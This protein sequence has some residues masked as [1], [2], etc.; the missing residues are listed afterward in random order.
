ME[1]SEHALN[2]SAYSAYSEAGASH[3]SPHGGSQT[4]HGGFD[5]DAMPGPDGVPPPGGNRLVHS[6]ESFGSQANLIGVVAVA[7][8]MWLTMRGQPWAKGPIDS[9]GEHFKPRNACRNIR[10]T[11]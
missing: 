3:V 7:R 8:H 9:T 5:P 4:G 10:L 2:A 6:R 1:S 11:L